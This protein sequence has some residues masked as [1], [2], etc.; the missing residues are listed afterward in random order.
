[1][2]LHNKIIDIESTILNMH[3]YYTYSRCMLVLYIR[4]TY[5]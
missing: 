1:M 5:V 4:S 2:D 3:M